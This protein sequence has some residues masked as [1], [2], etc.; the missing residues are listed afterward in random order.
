MRGNIE[1][2][3]DVRST[4]FRDSTWIIRFTRLIPPRRQSEMCRHR[5]RTLEPLRI[6]YRGL[7]RQCGDRTDTGYAHETLADAIV[8]HN[9]FD[10]VVELQEVR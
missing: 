1:R 2:A 3:S 10:L 5:P 9:A 8:P 7:E 6:I 4:R